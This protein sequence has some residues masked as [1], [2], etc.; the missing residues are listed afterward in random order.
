MSQSRRRASRS[1]YAQIIGADGEPI[2]GGGPPTFGVVLRGERTTSTR[3]DSQ[4]GSAAPDSRRPDRDRQGIGRRGRPRGRRHASRCSRSSRRRS[5]RSSASRRSGPPTARSARRSCSSRCPRRSASSTCLPTSS[6]TSASS[7]SPACRRTSSRSA[8][9]RRV[10]AE[11]VEVVTGEQLT[12]ENQDDVEQ[13][14]S[15]FNTILLVFA[16]VAL[17]VS[18]FIIYNTFSI[19]VAQR[20][21]EMALLARDR[22]VDAAGDDVDH[23]R[24]ARGRRRRVAASGSARASCSRAC[25]RRCSTRSAS[26]SRR[27]TSSIPPNALDRVAHRRHGRHRVLG[28]RPGPQG[29]AGPAR[30]GDARRRGR[31]ARRVRAP[32]GHRPRD[33]RRSASRLVLFALVRLAR[34]RARL[35]RPRRARGVHRR[36]RPRPG[37]RPA[38]QPGAS[39]R[40]CRRSRA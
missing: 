40:R 26:T 13:F 21:R 6:A 3:C 36:V 38:G 9:A 30:R 33:H 16:A 12:E 27:A 5:T 31:A 23:P 37:D 11:N 35:P 17:F 34:Q 22:R 24:S 18:C 4:P 7:P 29:V 2:G 25:S 28:G 10:S 20:T 32:H 15:V 19:I 14:L 39:A 1:P 8:S